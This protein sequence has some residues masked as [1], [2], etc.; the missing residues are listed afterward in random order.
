[1]SDTSELDPLSNQLP[2]VTHRCALHHVLDKSVMMQEHMS[3]SAFPALENSL[4][5]VALTVEPDVWDVMRILHSAFFSQTYTGDDAAETHLN[6]WREKQGITKSWDR[7]TTVEDLYPSI[8]GTPLAKGCEE[9]LKSAMGKAEPR[10]EGMKDVLLLSNLG[11]EERAKEDH[12]SDKSSQLEVS[13]KFHFRRDIFVDMY[14]V[15]T[16][17]QFDVIFDGKC[18]PFVPSRC[19]GVTFASFGFVFQYAITLGD[20]RERLESPGWLTEL[21]HSQTR[22]S[23]YTTAQQ[24]FDDV[25]SQRFSARDSKMLTG[26]VASTGKA[27]SVPFT[28]SDQNMHPTAPSITFGSTLA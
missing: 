2:W 24:D 19:P 3:L 26:S 14:T 28:R 21:M 13:A 1:M 27:V 6:F 12:E 5:E 11:A 20:V 10:L 23:Q 7:A 22:R 16:V 4:N 25:Y 8:K 9:I 17:L 15:Q 18:T